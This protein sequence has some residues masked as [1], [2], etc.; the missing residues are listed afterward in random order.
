MR[1]IGWRTRRREKVVWEVKLGIYDYF[2][3]DQYVGEW[4]NNKKTG[5]GRMKYDNGNEYNGDW[6]ND[7]KHGKGTFFQRL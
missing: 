7:Q 1:E 2:N 5:K 6:V 4:K 3:G